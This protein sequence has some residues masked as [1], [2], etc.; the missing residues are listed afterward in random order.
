[1]EA[2]ILGTKL[3]ALKPKLVTLGAKSGSPGASLR[4]MDANLGTLEGNSWLPGALWGALRAKSEALRF[5]PEAFKVMP[6]P[7][8]L[9]EAL[10]GQG[11]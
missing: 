11:A 2:K 4:P 7:R 10:G 1:M 6:G 8:S 9:F 5:N 3:D